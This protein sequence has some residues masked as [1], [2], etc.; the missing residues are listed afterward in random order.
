VTRLQPALALCALLAAPAHAAEESWTPIPRNAGSF[1]DL[2]RLHVERYPEATSRFLR[3]TGGRQILRSFNVVWI[4]TVALTATVMSQNVFDCAGHY[5]P[6][7]QHILNPAPGLPYDSFDWHRMFTYYG[8]TLHDVA[9]APDTL[10]VEAERL[11]C[12][13]HPLP[14]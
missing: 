10:M 14:A 3:S 9:D 2:G 1:V 5:A 13:A 12:A 7:S 6:L 4:K 8:P 11:V